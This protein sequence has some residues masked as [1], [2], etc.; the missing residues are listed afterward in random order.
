VLDDAPTVASPQPARQRPR[1]IGAALVGGVDGLLGVALPFAVLASLAVL[2]WAGLGRAEAWTPYIS[3]AADTWLLGHGVDIRF[4]VQGS[5]FTVTAAL[6]GPALVTVLCAVRAGR[7][8]AATGSPTT[9][10]IAQLVTTG[11]AAAGLLGLGSSAA[12][13]PVAWQAILLPLLVVA[14]GSLAGL[15]S[16]RPGVRP[17]PAGVRA[18]LM[19]ALLLL[20]AAAVVLTVL[21]FA[22]FADVVALD[23]SLDAGPVGGL[24][25]TCLQILAMPTFVVWAASWLVGA[26]VALGTGSVTGPFLGQVGPLPALPVLGAVPAAPPAWA[27][28]LLVVPVLAGFVAALLVRRRGADARAVPLGLVAGVV[29]G[30]VVGALAAASAGSAGPGRFVAVGPDALLVAGL[31]AALVGLPAMI[32]AAVVRPY[33]DPSRGVDASQ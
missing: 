25:L 23:E 18:G 16:G 12:A 30:L 31:T 33:V 11:L 2:A 17:L 32:G 26:G 21:L 19:A 28:A 27:A 4:A 5:P 24:V 9:A 6:L 15:R 29:A 22:R 10:W 1:R 13:A 7:R 3:A 8:A 20:A 14:A